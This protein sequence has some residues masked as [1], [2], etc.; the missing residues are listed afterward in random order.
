MF[1]EA[2]NLKNPRTA[3][4]QAAKGLDAGRKLALTGTPVENRLAD[5]WALFDLLVPGLLGD[6]R[7]F[8]RT[9]SGPIEGHGDPV[10]RAHL[11]RKLRPFL[12]RRTKEEVATELPRK[13]I[14][15]LMITPT[16][17]QMALHESQR[18]L[19]QERVRDEIARVGLMRAHI[20]VLTA[21]TR[22]RQICCDPRLIA[23][24]QSGCE[25]CDNQDENREGVR[26]RRA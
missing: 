22:L 3:G 15:P 10:A 9:Y 21:L 5:A 19:M 13:S 16:P 6:G 24:R 8:K 2:H 20:V 26:R 18:L 14:V 23:A 4:H 12:L 11:A 1:D 17:A 25:C 7:S